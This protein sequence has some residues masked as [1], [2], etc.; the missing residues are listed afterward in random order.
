MQLAPTILMIQIPMKTP[1]EIS[2]EV[3][4]NTRYYCSIDEKGRF[5]C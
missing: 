5:T 4:C 2:D 3:G 1:R